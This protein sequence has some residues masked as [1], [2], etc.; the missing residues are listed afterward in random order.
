MS[1]TTFCQMMEP[2]TTDRQIAAIHR[3]KGTRRELLSKEPATPLTVQTSL[4]SLNTVKSTKWVPRSP[5]QMEMS[6]ERGDGFGEWQHRHWISPLGGGIAETADNDG[7]VSLSTGEGSERNLATCLSQDSQEDSKLVHRK[8]TGSLLCDVPSV[9]LRKKKSRS[10]HQE[11]R[12]CSSFDDAGEKLLKDF[13]FLYVR[14]SNLAGETR[15]RPLNVSVTDEQI[16]EQTD[17]QAEDPPEEQNH[18]E[19]FMV[20]Q[21]YEREVEDA[22][23]SEA[24]YSDPSL[25]DCCCSQCEGC[26]LC[27]LQVEEDEFDLELEHATH[28]GTLDFADH[29]EPKTKQHADG[30]AFFVNHVNQSERIEFFMD[31]QHFTDLEGRANAKHR[32]SLPNIFAPT[33]VTS[34]DD[35]PR[36]HTSHLGDE[37]DWKS[38]LDV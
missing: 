23:R 30:G 6:I 17:A 34:P 26:S 32:L 2:Q 16:E 38:A 29:S 13:D 21:D 24:D 3:A 10:V 8:S 14:G 4:R 31:T 36:S 9:P 7:V 12:H 28:A 19:A 18:L 11:S 1:S 37:Q 15:E 20:L 35:V 5:L 33:A 25:H 27:C 22:A